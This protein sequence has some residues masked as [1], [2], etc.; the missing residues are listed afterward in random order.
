MKKLKLYGEKKLI[1]GFKTEGFVATIY[2]EGGKVRIDSKNSGLR[3]A[4]TDQIG[5]AVAAGSIHMVK[6]IKISPN[7]NEGHLGGIAHGIMP[8]KPGD[9]KF[10]EAL[11]YD[12]MIW[13]S[14]NFAGYK[15]SGALSKIIEE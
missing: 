4:L 9:D 10:L 11:Q 8:Q 1:L 12:E 6:P 15:I 2:V 3:E 7:P 13:A 14:G 5:R